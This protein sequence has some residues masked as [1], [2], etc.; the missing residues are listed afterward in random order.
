[1]C[2]PI[3]CEC[4]KRAISMKTKFIALESLD[5]CANAK[6]YFLIQLDMGGMKEKLYNLKMTLH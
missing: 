4:K 3:K 2:N 6:R 1:M 5:Q